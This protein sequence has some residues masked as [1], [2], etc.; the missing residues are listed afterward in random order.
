M[1]FESSLLSVLLSGPLMAGLYFY[2][3][4]RIRGESV[5]TETAFAGFRHSLVHLFLASF[6]SQVLTVLGLVC[7]ILPGL[8]LLVAWLFT[9]PLVIDK[10]LE[11][12]TAMRLSRKVISKHWWKFAGFLVVL[13][14][15]NLAGLLACVVGVFVT[16]S[17]SYAA[18]MYAYEDIISAR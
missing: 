8:Y 2:L 12:W 3:L 11:F 5:R 7:L 15:L 17:V 4:K 6:V 14:L 13:G 18:L 9:F 10:R 16:L 1:T